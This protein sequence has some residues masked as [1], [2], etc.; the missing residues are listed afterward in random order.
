MTRM[1]GIL[2]EDHCT[3]MIVHRSVRREKNVSVH[4]FGE[5]QNTYFV[6]NKVFFFENRAV[7]EIMCKNNVEPNRPQILI[8]RMRI[9]CWKSEATNTFLEYV[10]LIVFH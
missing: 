5:N 9:V 10:I 8:G 7:Y 6:F 2:H 1:K 3:F 4:S